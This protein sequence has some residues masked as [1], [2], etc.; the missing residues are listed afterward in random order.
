MNLK[1]QKRL[2]ADLLGVGKKKVWIDQDSLNEV[3][4]AIT[5]EDIRELINQGVIKKKKK[6]G[7]KRKKGKKK[8]GMGSRKGGK[9]ARKDEK[10]EYVRKVRAQRKFIKKLEEEGK[11]T[12]ETY[13]ELYRRISG[14][15]FRS[16]SHI[17]I[18][19]KKGG[20]IENEG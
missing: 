4:D 13:K 5:R 16:K 18:Y 8:Q 19:L 3:A 20:K 11:I 2:A 14:G 7:Q 9:G 12:H 15:F 1:T 17:E 10:R 6:Q